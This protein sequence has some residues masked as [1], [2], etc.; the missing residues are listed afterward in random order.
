MF[1]SEKAMVETI[2][3]VM[4]FVAAVGY[5]LNVVRKSFSTKSSGCAKGCGSACGSID[6]KRSRP[7]SNGKRPQHT[8]ESA[9]R[10]QS[11]V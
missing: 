2:I 5:L 7:K 3:I 4:L 9:Y 8:K 10:I 6:F 1:S 11:H